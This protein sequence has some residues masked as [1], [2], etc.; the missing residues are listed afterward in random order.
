MTKTVGGLVGPGMDGLRGKGERLMDVW[1]CETAHFC[2]FRRVSA[3]RNTR[4][5]AG[6]SFTSS[7]EA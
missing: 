5:D 1:V 7:I 4:W 2:Q 6:S 3:R